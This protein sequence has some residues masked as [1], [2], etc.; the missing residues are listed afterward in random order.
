MAYKFIVV[1]RSDEVG[2]A[3]AA[4]E[5]TEIAQG[6]YLED[7]STIL[8]AARA[9]IPLGHKIALRGLAEGAPVK[10]YGQIIGTA[11]MKIETGEHV[12]T[13]NL[14]SARPS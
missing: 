9:D 6:F 10:K 14:K 2:V 11:I 12:H 7:S 3:L 4:I 8:V 5:A 1:N 13:H